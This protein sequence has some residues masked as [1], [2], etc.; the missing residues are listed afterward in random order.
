MFDQLDK[1]KDIPTH[2]AAEAVKELSRSGNVKRW[3]LFRVKWTEPEKAIPSV[4]QCDILRNHT[5][6]IGGF[7]NSVAHGF[8]KI[9]H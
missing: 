9:F 2:T 4:L 1:F 5:D 7:A 8:G 3:R 6:N